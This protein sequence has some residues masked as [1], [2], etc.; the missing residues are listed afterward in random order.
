V[1]KPG[2]DAEVRLEQVMPDAARAE[3]TDSVGADRF[4]GR[5]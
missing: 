2:D 4:V 1:P 3:R 5:L